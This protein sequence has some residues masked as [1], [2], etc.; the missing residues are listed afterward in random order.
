MLPLLGLC[1]IIWLLLLEMRNLVATSKTS[2][3]TCSFWEP[4]T[5]TKSHRIHVSWPWVVSP[6]LLSLLYITFC[7]NSLVDSI[8]YE[9]RS[10]NGIKQAS[11]LGQTNCLEGFHS[12]LNRFAPKMIGLLFFSSSKHQFCFHKY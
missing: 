12:V 10:M 11:P 1:F 6:C 8:A 2:S 4:S 9:T 5:S 7:Y 3:V